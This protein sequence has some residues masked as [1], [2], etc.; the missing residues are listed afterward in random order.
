LELPA[1]VVLTQELGDFSGVRFLK[2]SAFSAQVFGRLDDGFGHPFVGLLGAPDERKAFA[3]G[4][5]LVLVG[6]IQT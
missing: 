4:D 1:A 6:I 2:V 5:S 3:L